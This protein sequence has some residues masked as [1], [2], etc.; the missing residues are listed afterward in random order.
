MHNKINR[1][2]QHGADGFSLIEVM[3][4]TAVLLVVVVMVGDVFRQASSSWDSG[5][6]RAEGGMVVRGVLG[7][8]QR[9]LSK[10]IDG[11]R[12][13]GIWNHDAPV[14]VSGNTLEFI[15]PHFDQ[16]KPARTEDEKTREKY[17]LVTYKA[18]SGKVTREEATLKCSKGADGE[19]W[20]VD[21]RSSAEIYKDGRGFRPGYGFAAT[22]EFEADEVAPPPNVDPDVFW[23]VPTVSL[24]VDFVRTGSFSGLRVRSLGP[25]GKLDTSDDIMVR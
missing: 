8:I 5:Y 13:P 7:S 25:D 18:G 22:F 24:R 23:T 2:Q 17:L 15:R 9:E 1:R 11:R 3:V 14:H 21:K 6:A 12:F 10:A 19:T 20:A 4:A 16:Q